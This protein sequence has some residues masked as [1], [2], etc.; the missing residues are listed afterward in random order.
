WLAS[1]CQL[2]D[3]TFKNKKWNV[4]LSV[5]DLERNDGSP[6]K[7]YMMS[8]NLRQALDVQNK[9]PPPVAEQKL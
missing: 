2:N 5:E 3:V 7:P 9:L 1:L 8:Q 6:E 4:L